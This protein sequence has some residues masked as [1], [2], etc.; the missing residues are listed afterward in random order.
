MSATGEAVVVLD[1][2]WTDPVHVAAGLG[3]GDGALVLLSDGGPG[4][5]WSH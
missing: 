3:G 1:R 5:R 4:G 2:P